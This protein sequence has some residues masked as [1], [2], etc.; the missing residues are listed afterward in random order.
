MKSP[1][2]IFVSLLPL[3]TMAA[4]PV[5]QPITVPSF[6]P[7]FRQIRERAEVLFGRRDG[8]FP[9]PDARLN[10]FQNPEGTVI[11]QQGKVPELEPM[12]SDETLLNEAVAALKGKG[13][14]AIQGNRTFFAVGGKNYGEGDSISVPLRAGPVL[15]RV[16][17]ISRSGVTLT[18]NQV[19]AEIR[20]NQK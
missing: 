6:G 16:T 10:L 19:E 5:D 18:L 15:L 13:G 9:P 7:R 11:V 3:A 17:R 4:Q 20:F 14:F 1:L 8:A 2:L 12:G